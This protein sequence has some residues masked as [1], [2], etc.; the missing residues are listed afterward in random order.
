MEPMT[1]SQKKSFREWLHGW[2]EEKLATEAMRLKRLL[3]T[4]DMVDSILVDLTWELFDMVRDECVFRVAGL[5][6]GGKHEEH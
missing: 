6:L 3:D 2:T 4:P 1:D 5:G